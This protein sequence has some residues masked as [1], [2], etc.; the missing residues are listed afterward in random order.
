MPSKTTTATPK[1]RRGRPPGDGPTARMTTQMPRELFER[2]EAA[3]KKD[4][5]SR[6]AYVRRALEAAVGKRS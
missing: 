3:A 4:G 2:V 6:D 5:R 1:P